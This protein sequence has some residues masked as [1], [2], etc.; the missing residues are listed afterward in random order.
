MTSATQE[1]DSF[2]GGRTHLRRRVSTDLI[3]NH[4]EHLVLR[5]GQESIKELTVNHGLRRADE[6]EQI[7]TIWADGAALECQRH[8]WWLAQLD[9]SEVREHE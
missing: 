1:I 5:I 7:G 3:Q 8:A 4:A 9:D 6:L 2:G